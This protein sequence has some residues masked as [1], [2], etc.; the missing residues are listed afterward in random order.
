MSAPSFVA[1]LQR[2]AVLDSA[3]RPVAASHKLRAVVLGA[4]EELQRSQRAICRVVALYN[5]LP[6]RAVVAR[7][8][9][10]GDE[11]SRVSPRGAAVHQQLNHRSDRA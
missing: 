1:V 6:R 8:A 9:A 11:A 3:V 4:A 2:G 10:C 5:L 7:V